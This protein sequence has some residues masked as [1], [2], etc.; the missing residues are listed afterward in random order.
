M[1]GRRKPLS[2]T[3]YFRNSLLTKSDEW[4]FTGQRPGNRRLSDAYMSRNVFLCDVTVKS[5]SCLC[6]HCST[7]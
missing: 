3:T 7:A 5:A 4:A 2:R 1:P 6:N